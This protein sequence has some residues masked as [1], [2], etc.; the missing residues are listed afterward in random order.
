[1]AALEILMI[2]HNR[3]EYLKKALPSVCNQSYRNFRLII[4]DNNSN[5]EVVDYLKGW[6]GGLCFGIGKSAIEVIYNKTNE[7]LADVTTKVFKNCTGEFVGK[8]DADMIIPPDWAS[9]LI[10]KHQERHYG[11][12]GGFHFRPEDLNGIDPVIENGIWRKHHIGG[13]FIIRREDFKGYVGKGVM[14]LSEYQAE[15]GLLNGYLWDPI[16]WVEHMEDARSEH[17]I[18]N[19]EYNNYKI[20]TRGISLERYQTGIANLTYLRENTK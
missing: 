14:G 20:K 6:D 10:A 13:Q 1:M 9:R 18:N 7:S 4:W 11:F 17:Y 16:L 15:I 12:L 5:S 3:L 8:V 2:T 19:K